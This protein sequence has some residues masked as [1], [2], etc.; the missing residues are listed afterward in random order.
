M[1]AKFGAE[2]ID[3]FTALTRKL[4]RD[5]KARNHPLRN[6]QPWS[7]GTTP[8]IS[9][10]PLRLSSS[11]LSSLISYP[12]ISPRT[13]SVPHHLPLASYSRTIIGRHEHHLLQVIKYLKKASLPPTMLEPRGIKPSS[14]DIEPQCTYPHQDISTPPTHIHP[15]NPPTEPF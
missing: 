12:Y 1:L 10:K 7:T 13:I 9:Y 5:F 15:S 4:E 6:T 8:E 14:N 11:K 2:S 3:A